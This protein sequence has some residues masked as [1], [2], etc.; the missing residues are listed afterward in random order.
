MKVYL[1]R[2]VDRYP[3][4]HCDVVSRR[5]GIAETMYNNNK[6]ENLSNNQDNNFKGLVAK[7]FEEK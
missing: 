3:L 4:Q 2:A 1:D 5:Q 6:E 7:N